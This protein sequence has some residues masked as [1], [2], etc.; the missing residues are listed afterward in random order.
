[1]DTW[2]IKRR[3]IFAL[4]ILAL[5]GF[6]SVLIPGIRILIIEFIENVIVRRPSGD[7]DRLH[8]RIQHLAFFG[9]ML[10]A[11]VLFGTLTLQEQ[12]K[13][14]LIKWH[15]E[16]SFLKWYDKQ[17]IASK[18]GFYSAAIIAL[19]THIIMYS[20][21][22]LERHLP[23]FA[24][25]DHRRFSSDRWFHFFA[26]SL[27]FYYMNWVTGILQ[28][29]FLSFTVFLVIKSFNINNRLYAV[30]IAGIFVTFP[31]IAESNQFFHDAAPYYFAA[32]LSILAFYLTNRFNRGWI[33][34]IVLIVLG[35][36][37]YQSKISMAMMASLIC[38]VLYIM[39]EKPNFK[40]F[41]KYSKRYLFLIFGGLVIY[42][43]T[44][45]IFA[46]GVGE[47][48]QGGLRN[49]STLSAILRNVFR[50]YE[51]VIHY[52]FSNRFII[53]N[54]L[55]IIAYGILTIMGFLFFIVP[56]KKH[57]G[58]SI[59]HLATATFLIFLLPF[60]ANFTSMFSLLGI[61]ALAMTSY[62]FTFFLILPL[63][64]LEN[65][66][67]NTF[68][69]SKIMVLSLVFIIGYYISFSNFIYFRGQ[70]LTMH[71]MQLANR[72]VGRI[73]PLLPYSNN[74]QVFITGNLI[75]NPIF[76]HTS[77]FREYTPRASHFDNF[78]GPND[79]RD[80]P[81]N[82]FGRIIQH[83][84][85]INLQHP[86]LERQQYLLDRAISKGMPVYPLEGSVALIDGTVVVILNFF[87]RLDVEEIYNNIFLI[88]AKH[89]GKATNLKF[90]Y[91]WYLYKS[92]QRVKQ[93]ITDNTS[94]EIY[95]EVGDPGVYQI[96][97]FV[98]FQDG[99]NIIDFFSAK[100]EVSE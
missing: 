28:V 92:S 99:G 29:I 9:I 53:N 61:E 97:V 34:G 50:V 18:I 16:D 44:V 59:I 85:G 79:F 69:L 54:S 5:F 76:P 52:F 67:I 4:S 13:R 35:L 80:W 33:P 93:I 6:A 43:L 91:I 68:G 46:S 42:Y 86:H 98:R 73:E 45:P 81:Q 1:M 39:K 30:L 75:A 56:M 27:N 78:G 94:N 7:V 20:S 87:G 74:N 41:F 15:E 88:N 14:F 36:A 47:Y 40:S 64:L 89:T 3:I 62:A 66:K 19:L 70:V 31:T 48:G 37:T 65:F 10:C 63:I 17:T 95:L 84:V 21:I 8:I 77:V 90:E 57:I 23:G 22:I 72:I 60:A 24:R 83:R 55:L 26:N 38:L 49:I 71:S 82:L 12:I 11:I 96:R 51:E 32:F 58:K 2:S 25:T 100:F